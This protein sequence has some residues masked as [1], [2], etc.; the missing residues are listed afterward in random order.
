V[1][2]ALACVYPVTAAHTFAEE[3]TEPL[4]VT[5][6]ASGGP[7][8]STP[9]SADVADAAL[10]TPGPWNL[11]AYVG[12][13]FQATVAVFADADPQATPA[14]FTATV[15]WGDGATTSGAA[16]AANPGGPGFVV[17]AGH[18]YATAGT[19]PTTVTITD[20]GAS[21]ITATGT[22]TAT[23]PPAAGAPAPAAPGPT[24]APLPAGSPAG[25]PALGVSPPRLASPRTFS[26]RLT[27]PATAVRC[28]GVARVIALPARAQPAPLRGGASLGSS[29]FLLSPGESRTATI[30]VP[31]RLRRALRRARAA[32][33]AG[34]A[35][36]FAGGRSRATTGPSAVVATTGLR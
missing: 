34:V 12:S 24:P 29:L 13:P 5:V 3:G 11:S 15:S 28:R 31:A 16:V 18:T 1:A 30:G 2:S 4:T 20:D 35:I 33:L 9:T 23:A 17:A 6:T 19:F 25:A 36:A 21:T 14:S 7:P 26:V 22:A 32:R 27:C 10:S 8:A